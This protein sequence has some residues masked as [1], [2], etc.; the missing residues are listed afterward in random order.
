MGLIRVNRKTGGFETRPYENE[1]RLEAIVAWM[2][3]QRIA[4]VSDSLPR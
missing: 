4:I 1:I 3:H 2:S